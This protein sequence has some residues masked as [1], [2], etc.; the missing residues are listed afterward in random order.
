MAKDVEKFHGTTTVGIVAD[1]C[2]VLAAET[3]ATIGNL[4]ASKEDKKIYKIDDRVAMTTCGGAGDAQQA[5]R[6]MKAE[7]NLYKLE[8]G[9]MTVNA[10]VTLLANILQ[11]S[12][13]VPYIIMPIIG[14]VDSKGRHVFSVDPVGGITEDKFMSTGSGSPVAFGVLEA[15]YK[16]NMT[17][18]EAVGLAVRSIRSARERDVY[19]GGKRIDVAVISQKGVRFLSQED[20]NSFV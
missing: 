16:E 7:I 1:D 8:R 18:D 14:G 20:V 15:G 9:E 17:T 12:K 4:I 6:I 3:K 11:S 10:I 19:S 5:V 13:V 2:V